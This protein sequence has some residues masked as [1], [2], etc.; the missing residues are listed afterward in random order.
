MSHFVQD[1]V[2]NRLRNALG[3]IAGAAAYTGL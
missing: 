1:N 2:R 3:P